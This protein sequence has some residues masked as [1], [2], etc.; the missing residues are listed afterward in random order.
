MKETRYIKVN[1]N[2]KRIKISLNWRISIILLVIGVMFLT[3]GRMYLLKFEWVHNGRADLT[4]NDLKGNELVA[5]KGQWEFYWDKLL[6]PEDFRTEKSP[7]MDSLMKVPGSWT[8]GRHG[9][10]VYPKHGVATYRLLLS[11][12]EAIKDPAV[13]IRHVATSYKLYV[14]GKL[15]AEAGKVSDK[16]SDFKEGEAPHI[17]ELPNDTKEV[18]LIVQVANLNYVKGGLRESLVFGSKQV[19]ERQRMIVLIMQ[20]FFVGSIF[21]FSVYYLLLFLLQKKNKTALLFSLLCFI[22]VLRSVIWGEIPILIFFPNISYSAMTYINYLTGYN[23]MPVMILFVASMYPMEYKKTIGRLVL[24]PTLFFE[25]LLFMPPHL[26]AIFTEYLY[27]VVFIQM[28]Y[29]IGILV[30]AVLHKR[31]YAIVMFSAI[32]IFILTI[33]QDIF[34]YKGYGAISAS[35]RF[36]YGHFIVIIAMAFIQAMQEANTHK[37][38][39]LYN[40]NLIEAD[41]LKDKIMA[42]EMSFL[43]AQIKPHFLYNALNAILNVCETDGKKA[44]GLIVDLAV[45]LRGSLEFNHLDKRVTIEKELEFID[46]Y[47]N[48][49]KARFGQKIQCIKVVDC[50]A[51]Y[52]IPALIL[53]PLVENAIRHGISKKINGG[54]VYIRIKQA[55]E[56]VVFEVQDDGVGI[57]EKKLAMLLSEDRMDQRVGLINIQHRLLRLYGR[58]LDITS[59]VGGGTCVRLVIPEGR[60]QI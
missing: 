23:L 56:G 33:I 17:I 9:I 15:S 59:L 55:D 31:A 2:K 4:E 44:G 7:K 28:I 48:I 37:K 60:K 47:F 19:L 54:T 16:W 57:E 49:E 26:M 53:Q 30:K 42:T 43:Q 35:Y 58:G 32:C 38:L 27:I 3:T 25:I 36:L 41:R 12:P 52:Q 51:D 50:S 21:I 29:I 20:L 40:E 24:L 14:N 22:T 5:L 10:Q 46:T 34:Y 6:L 13:R 8:E 45:Y 39:I 11:Y 18:E 1:Q